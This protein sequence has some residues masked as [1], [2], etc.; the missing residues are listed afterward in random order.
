MAMTLGRRKLFRLFSGVMV[1]AIPGTR[2]LF[3]AQ[4]PRRVGIVGGGILGGSIAYHLV[5]RGADVTVF[6][7]SKPAAGATQN[8]FAW[9]NASGSKTPFHYHRL[10]R[11]GGLGY[12]DLER[13]LGGD[14]KVQWGGSLDWTLDT[15]RANA[16]RERVAR[17]QRWGYP[18]WLIERAEFR[19]LE[20]NVVP[21]AVAAAYFSEEEGSIDPVRATEVLLAHAKARGARVEYPCEVTDLDM[22]WGRLHGVK[23]TSGDFEL[24]VLVIAAGTDTPKV[25]AMA[26]LR[27]PLVTSRGVLAHTKPADRLIN[28]VVLSPGAHMKQKTDGRLVAGMGFG[29]TPSK[30]ATEEEGEKILASGAEFLPSLDKLELDR[31]TLGFRPLPKDGHPIVGFPRGAPDIYLSVMHSGITLAPV[32]GKLAAMEILDRIEVDLLQHYRIER[33]EDSPEN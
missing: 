2:A 6:E 28:R 12:R 29:A 31:V 11:L 23:T 20:S 30:E 1:A 25:A 26:G 32:V 13:E 16:I 27:V 22:R 19:K 15:A 24:D 5:R 7:K 33:F 18:S 17:S 21:G 9:F 4:T 14:L 3:A 10:S 8:S